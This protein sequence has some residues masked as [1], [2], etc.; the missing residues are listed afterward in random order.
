MTLGQDQQRCA[1]ATLFI[2]VGDHPRNH[3]LAN[4]QLGFD[5]GP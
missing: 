1:I 3:R 5:S 4:S 2:N